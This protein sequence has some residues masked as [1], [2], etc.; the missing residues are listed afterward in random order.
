MSDSPATPTPP[1]A[2]PDPGR[3][4]AAVRALALLCAAAMVLRHDFAAVVAAAGDSA[5]ASALGAAFGEHWPWLL[6]HL[7]AGLAAAWLGEK[8]ITLCYPLRNLA[9]LAQGGNRAAAVQGGVHALGAAV[10]AGA[11]FGG[12]DGPTLRV[13][14]V[15]FALALSAVLVVALG[16]RIVTRFKDHEEIADD[17][18]AVALASGGLHLGIAILAARACAGEFAGWSASLTA[19][20]LALIWVLLLWPLRQLVLAHVLLG[21]SARDLDHAQAALRRTDLGALE[22]GLYLL[23]ALALGLA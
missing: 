8:L 5:D 14:A 12:T 6:T 15:F 22:G 4:L 18:L 10:L 17:N 1:P 20:G 2:A 21:M 3:L 11:C 23:T 13:G 19:F 16:H 7:L 9:G